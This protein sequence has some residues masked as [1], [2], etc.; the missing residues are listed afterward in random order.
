MY[1]AVSISRITDGTSNTVMIG[2]R[3]FSFDLYWGW[4][5][6]YQYDT[7]SGAANSYTI[8]GYGNTG[9][10]QDY[11][12]QLNGSPCPNQ[13]PYHFGDGPNNVHSPCSWSQLWS[14]HSGS[15][16]NFVFADG[17]VRWI[18]YQA[19]L[20]VVNLSTYAGGEINT[21]PD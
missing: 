4:W 3:P 12:Y 17:S 9:S 7:T 5:S 21:N 13:P 16:G 8:G 6:Y 15:G 18:G 1:H 14:P 11:A 20:I 2:E 19:K 10:Y